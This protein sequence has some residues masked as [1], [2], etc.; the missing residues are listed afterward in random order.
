MMLES[1]GAP[2][3]NSSNYHEE[4]SAFLFLALPRLP[5]LA[6]AS[7]N[8]CFLTLTL[9]GPWAARQGTVRRLKGACRRPWQWQWHTAR[10][11]RSDEGEMLASGSIQLLSDARGTE[12]VRER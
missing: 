6:D 10:D 1:L 7:R 12:L 5:R 3:D 11:D 2:L 4:I 9:S 8:S